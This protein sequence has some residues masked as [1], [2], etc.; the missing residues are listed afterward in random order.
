MTHVTKTGFRECS[1]VNIVSNQFLAKSSSPTVCIW[2]LILI[3]ICSHSPS[4]HVQSKCVPILFFFGVF[5]RESVIFFRI[6]PPHM[7]S[8]QSRI[9]N[10]QNDGAGNLKN[11]VSSPTSNF[12]WPLHSLKWLLSHKIFRPNQSQAPETGNDVRIGLK[13]PT[14]RSETVYN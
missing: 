14:C 8:R 7:N 3:K 5:S 1:Y 11:T 6:P 9:A 12:G 4:C 2:G 10:P 13:S